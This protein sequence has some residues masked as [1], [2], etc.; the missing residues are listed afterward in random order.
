MG[1][2]IKLSEEVKKY[3]KEAIKEGLEHEA[4][5]HTME[6]KP[7][8]VSRLAQVEIADR[9]YREGDRVHFTYD[10]ALEIEKKL[11][12]TGWRLPTRSEWVLICE[13]FGQK[14]GC[15]EGDTLAT[16]LGIN[17][18]GWYDPEDNHVYSA[19]FLGLYWSSTPS[20]SA[21]NAYYLSFS[22]SSVNPSTNLNRYTGRSLRLVRGV[23]TRNGK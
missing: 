15:L 12:G 13:E 11:S 23:E 16:N 17:Y 19:G 20:S 4:S 8:V 22:T 9:D 21:T 7:L 2:E 18:N 6:L 1:Q 3:I 14:D 10:E 5:T